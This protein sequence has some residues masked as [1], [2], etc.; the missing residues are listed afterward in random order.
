MKM[1]TFLARSSAGPTPCA[2][3]APAYAKVAIS[4]DNT[5]VAV[6][7]H[8]L[9]HTHTPSLAPNREYGRYSGSVQVREG[10]A[11]ELRTSEKRSSSHSGKKAYE[12]SFFDSL[13]ITVSAC[14]SLSGVSTIIV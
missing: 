13:P 9:L 11:P 5:T 10:E 4:A 12:P 8:T 6:V 1:M 2:S 14:S 7:A 3:P